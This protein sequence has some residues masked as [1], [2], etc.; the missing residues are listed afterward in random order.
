M[1]AEVLDSTKKASEEAMTGSMW[2]TL[3]QVDQ[4]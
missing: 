2:H 3:V 1:L 4:L